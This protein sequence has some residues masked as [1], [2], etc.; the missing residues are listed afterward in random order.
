VLLVLTFSTRLV[1][2]VSYLGLGR[3]F[4]ANTTGHGSVRRIAAV[5]AML[6][7]AIAGALLRQP[8]SR[9]VR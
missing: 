7:G 8:R 9:P 1:D 2:A 3:V 5:L 6:L 4:T